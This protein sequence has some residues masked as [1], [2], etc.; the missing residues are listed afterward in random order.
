MLKMILIVLLVLQ[1]PRTYYRET[2]DSLWTS[3][4]ERVEVLGTVTV[5][6]FRQ[7]KAITFY[8]GDEHGHFLSCIWPPGQGTQPRVGVSVKVLGVRHKFEVPERQPVLEIDPV[9]D[10]K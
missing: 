7:D 4:H 5:V 1:A 6:T 3:T 9:E 2:I 8:I 10:V